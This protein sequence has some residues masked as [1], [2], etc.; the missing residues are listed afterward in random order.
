MSDAVP[1]NP[2]PG[3]RCFI[4]L[5]PGAAS[6]QALCACRESS[7]HASIGPAGSVRWLEPAALHLTLRFL[8]NTSA[9]QIDSFARALPALASAL[10]ASTV[11]RLAVWP[12]RARPRLLVLELAANPA[13]FR[14]AQAC[15]AQARASGFA[16]EQRDFRAHV[17]LARLRPGGAFGILP[18]PSLTVRFDTLALMQSSPAPSGP[19]YTALASVPLR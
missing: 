13:L 18:Q 6:L 16:P 15:E 12:N 17:T 4:A 9:T 14:L 7:Q 5:L 19:R 3:T 11:R 1:A 8:G 10:P 2:E